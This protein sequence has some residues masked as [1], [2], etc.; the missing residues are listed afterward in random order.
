MRATLLLLAALAAAASSSPTPPAQPK[1]G[2]G[3]AEV[4]HQGVTAKLYGSGA[5]AYWLFEPAAPRPEQAPLLVFL[6]GWSGMQPRI[7]GAWIE[8]LV[9]RGSIVVF[10]L[11]QDSLRTPVA[12]FT[13]NA[14]AAVKDAIHRLQTEPGHVQPMLDKFALAGHSMGGVVAANLAAR[15]ETDGL[16]RP[17]AMMAVQPGKTWAR[18][19]RI[20][21]KLEDLSR[22]P[23]GTLLLA[24][25]GDRDTLAR[26]VDAK[27]IFRESTRIP[28]QDKN[29]VTLVSDGHGQP[30][31]TAD[32]FAPVAPESSRGVDALDWYGTWKLL[33]G[34]TDAAF[35]GKNRRYA[36]GNT[37]EQRF[38]GRWSDGVAVKELLV[39]G[40]P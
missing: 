22:I 35:F 14:A 34:L 26:D 7:Y 20:A 28:F 36:L 9:K 18:A 15:W 32:H 23:A 27:R 8:H 11:Y 10:P 33:D 21:V 30:A 38:M 3:G 16:P 29:Y 24:V 5:R 19:R 40:Q 12:E 31:L 1:T 25:T 13:P 4:S 6:H 2:P 17:R 37:P 39:T